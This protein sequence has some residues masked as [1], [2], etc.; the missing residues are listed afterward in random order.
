MSGITL[1]PAALALATTPGRSHALLHIYQLAAAHPGAPFEVRQRQAQPILG[2][3]RCVIQRMLAD[4]VRA[5]LIERAPDGP[6]WVLLDAEP[7]SQQRATPNQVAPGQSGTSEP[8]PSH[9]L[10]TGAR[11][12]APG[13]PGVPDRARALIDPDERLLCPLSRSPEEDGSGLS[14]EA[15]LP[16]PPSPG[17][18]RPITLEGGSINQSIKSPGLIGCL[19]ESEHRS[20]SE[21]R[22]PSGAPLASGEGGGSAAGEAPPPSPEA[23]ALESM[24]AEWERLR[25]Q[26][27]AAGFERMMDDW[28]SAPDIDHPCW[29]DAR[30]M[31][32]EGI[33]DGEMGLWWIRWAFHGETAGFIRGEV[34][35]F[36]DS[37][38]RDG[39]KVPQN[40]YLR[41][42]VVFRR[43]K[44][45]NRLNNVRLY[46]EACE[47][48][49]VPDN[50][51]HLPGVAERP[52]LAGFAEALEELRQRRGGE[53]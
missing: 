19:N 28:W 8:A 33:L 29:A 11:P 31:L 6:E 34:P 20:P 26:R 18:D 10:P 39:A 1:S 7:P 3:D 51:V 5:G 36:G 46:R 43:S 15:N 38:L 25:K 9:S 16:P 52:R 35:R 23:L 32:R 22:S 30:W 44:L 14:S 45:T 4:L 53:G 47:R 27:F 42:D 37:A 17:S 21:R 50:L 40:E 49:E 41:I 13:R 2:I 24:R 48:A 12:G